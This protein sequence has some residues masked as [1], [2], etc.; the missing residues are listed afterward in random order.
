MKMSKMLASL[1]I[2]AALAACA[3]P[4]PP[5]RAAY[6]GHWASANVVLAISQEGEL[7]Y[8]KV[9]GNHSTSIEAP[10]LEFVGNNFTA[11]VGPIKTTFVVS[12]APH[13]DGAVWK[14]T[15]DGVELTKS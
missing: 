12:V 2:V 9:D 4:I 3:K 10:V 14:M 6:V 11:G 13:K 15:V 8:R 7:S 1:A 5:E